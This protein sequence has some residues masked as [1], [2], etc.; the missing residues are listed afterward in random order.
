MY[1]AISIGFASPK[2]LCCSLGLLSL[3]PKLEG[4]LGTLGITNYVK[5]KK[6]KYKAKD[7]SDKMEAMKAKVDFTK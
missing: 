3:Y 5:P 1:A 6:K 4:I 2:L 7:V